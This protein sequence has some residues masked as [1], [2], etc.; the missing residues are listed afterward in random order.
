M[1][2]LIIEIL[3]FVIHFNFVELWLLKQ[4]RLDLSKKYYDNNLDCNCPN[5]IC[6]KD[7]IIVNESSVPF[8]NI[9]FLKN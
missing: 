8:Q 4:A 3:I 7:N 5:E 2:D 9:I 1:I 6:Q